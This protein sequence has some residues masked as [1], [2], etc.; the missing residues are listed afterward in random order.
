MSRLNKKCFH[1]TFKQDRFENGSSIGT[2]NI[3][4]QSIIMEIK[5]TEYKNECKP[6]IAQ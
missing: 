3:K 5:V 1:I 4:D 2:E 6:L